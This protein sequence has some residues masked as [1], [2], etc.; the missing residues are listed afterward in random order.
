M[1]GSIKLSAPATKE[2]WEIAVLHEDADLLALNKPPGLLTSPDRYD[3]NRPNLMRLLHNGIAAA[4][5]WARERGLQYLANA[6]RLDFETSGVLLLARNKPTLVRLA[7]QFGANQPRKTYVALIPGT[8]PQPEWEVNAAL[9][10]HPTKLGLMRVDLK[11]GKKSLTR[12]SVREQ[13]RGYA[14][15]E[16][17]P[18]TGRTHQIRVHLK[19]GGHP[20]CGDKLYG[21]PPLLLSHLKSHYSLKP[22]QSERPLIQSVALHAERLELP[23]PATGQPLRI[24]AD[25]PKDLL[26]AVKYLRRYAAV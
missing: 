5:P 18:L 24:A 6:H 16:C 10:P 12:F 9:S 20:I 17:R 26:V 3:P 22:G 21:G 4:K 2:F 15:V 25:W 19:H 13:F 14:L 23:H 7:D 8:P 1:T 11:G